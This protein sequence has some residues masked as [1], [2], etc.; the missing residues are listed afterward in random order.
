MSFGFNLL[1]TDQESG[2]R[3]GVLHTS[4]GGILTPVFMPV[5]SQATVKT[6]TPDDLHSLGFGLILC[7][8][9]HLYLRPGIEVVREM[10]GLHR[11]MGWDGAIL[12][13]SGG[14][15]LFSLSPLT[16]VSEEGVLFRSHIDGS[17]RMLTPETAIELQQGFGSDIMMAFDQPPQ[18]TDSH[19]EAA[20]ATERTYRW[21]QR[22]LQV[23]RSDG[24]ALF[25]IAQGGLF[26][27]L[28]RQSAEAIVSLGFEGYAVGG[29]S[30][31]EDKQ[32]TYEMVKE[33][34]SRFPGEKPRYLMGVGA[35]EDLL[36]S[37]SLGI[38]MFDSA[39]PTRVARN[40]ALFTRKGRRNIRNA[41]FRLQDAPF[42]PGCSCYTC[43]HFS[44]AYLHHLFRARELLVY[45]LATIH[46]LHFIGVLMEAIRTSINEGDF[47]RLKKEFLDGYEITDQAARVEQKRKWLAGRREVGSEM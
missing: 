13:D 25:G 14:Y 42:D 31:G 27:E 40:G 15:Q 24:Q 9:Y 16:G 7:N 8:T 5:G 22:C 3:S 44:A 32:T 17:E 11:F 12:T 23:H 4:H 34:V 39:L 37:V 43:A 20:Q 21:A 18:V 46:N 19:D 36:E 33:T 45:R 6:L 41:S 26:A 35:P 10:G 30:L 1:T 38:D 29:L 28:R 2:A 47:C